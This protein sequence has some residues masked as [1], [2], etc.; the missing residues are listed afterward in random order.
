MRG[1]RLWFA[2]LLIVLVGL[3]L[4][5]SLGSGLGGDYP[6][7]ECSTC[8]YPGPAINALA[9]GHTSQFFALQPV[10]GS[11]SLVLRAPFAALVSG[12]LWR[13]R[14][15]ALVLLLIVAGIAWWIARVLAERGKSR[16]MQ[17][18]VAALF[19]ASPLSFQA[20]RWGHPE[21]VLAA[22]LCVAAVILAERRR[23]TLAGV[24]LGLAIATKQWALLA[25]IP[26]L[27]VAAGTRRRLLL[28]A[29]GTALV[30]TLP[31]ALGD[32]HRFLNISTSYSGASGKFLTPSNIWW[33][34]GVRTQVFVNGVSATQW[35]LPATLKGLA[36]PLVLIVVLGLCATYWRAGL[37]RD[38]VGALSLLALI[39]LLRCMLDT[40]TYGYHHL[41]LLL[42]LAA[43]EGLGRRRLPWVALAIAGVTLL[44]NSVV[45]PSASNDMLHQ[46]YLA[47][48]LPLLIY[49]VMTVFNLR[50]P[51]FRSARVAR[52]A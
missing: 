40:L 47:W 38:A 21:E 34:F 17:L 2:A 12:D 44:M 41:P 26:V 25:V 15:G 33:P 37:R 29:I 24:T 20:M 46:V 28:G 10:M 31:M 36:H 1:S 49:L 4:W 7:P 48:T 13:Y 39:F 11:F 22:A 43:A 16:T 27:I 35:Q 52:A 19:V 30:L 5:V 9:A 18:T 45:A 32:M 23:G 8:D 50:L 6:G 51:A 42:A 14:V 3:A